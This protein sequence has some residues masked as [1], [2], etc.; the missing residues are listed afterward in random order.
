MTRFVTLFMPLLLLGQGEGR[1]ASPA[2]PS[3]VNQE[4]V[5]KEALSNY[6]AA[7]ALKNN[8][9]P[10]AQQRYQAALTG[11]QSLIDAGVHSGPLYYNL[12]NAHLSL[13]DIG[14][15]I[16]NY[17]RAVRLSPDNENIERNLQF[18]RKLCEVQIPR[19]AGDAVVRTIFFWHFDTALATRLKVFLWSYCTVWLLL[20]L[21]LFTSRRIPT[22]FWATVLAGAI[23]VASSTS[24]GWDTLVARSRLEGAVVAKNAVLRKG[25]GEYYDP[26]LDR[27]L[28]PGVEFRALESRKDVNGDSWFHIRL[29]GGK[30]G[31]L[32]DNQVEII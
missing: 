24:V 32:R 1:P 22:L 28:Q 13:G 7:A 11:F 15:A 31:W 3:S 8:S 25:S 5:L 19:S 2:A 29:E 23:T 18:A 26:E 20:G 12:A 21:R 16:V 6:E 30:S 17:H 14:R 27:P 10:E 4:Q 9:S